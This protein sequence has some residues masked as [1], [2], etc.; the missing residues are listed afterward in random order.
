MGPEPSK[1]DDFLK[2]GGNFKENFVFQ[3]PPQGHV[4]PSTF[5]GFGVL[6]LR[7]FQGSHRSARCRKSLTSVRR[8]NQR[9]WTMSDSGCTKDY[10]EWFHNRV[11]FKGTIS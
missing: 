4:R 6:G 2:R 3:R 10:P 7:S 5:L 1:A 8:L 9:S 11:P